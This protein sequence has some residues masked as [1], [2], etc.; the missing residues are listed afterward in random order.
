MNERWSQKGPYSPFERPVKYDVTSDFPPVGAHPL[1]I[2]IDGEWLPYLIGAAKSLTAP[3]T[4]DEDLY[5][6]SCAKALEANKLLKSLMEASEGCYTPPPHGAPT[7]ECHYDFSLTDGGW[8]LWPDSDGEF[9]EWIYGTG[10]QATTGY[11]TT[12]DQY[13]RRLRIK[14]VYPVAAYVNE[15]AMEYTHT[16]ELAMGGN[17]ARLALLQAITPNDNM[18][19][20]VAAETH[21]DQ[22][23][24]WV[25]TRAYTGELVKGVYLAAEAGWGGNLDITAFVARQIDVRGVGSQPDC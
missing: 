11:D 7:W 23:R 1:S 6:D 18:A 20:W 4:W 15:M 25:A 22:Y 19:L 5:I 24:S 14:K 21:L 9:G 13:V 8:E 2:C 3:E 12:I 17:S 10:W 16:I